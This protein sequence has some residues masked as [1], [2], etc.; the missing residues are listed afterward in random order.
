M[1][2][3]AFTELNALFQLPLS[4]TE[5][6]CCCCL[7]SRCVCVFSSC[8]AAVDGEPQR[9]AL[10]HCSAGYGPHLPHGDHGEPHRPLSGQGGWYVPH[11]LSHSRNISFIP[12]CTSL[13]HPTPTLFFMFYLCFSF[14]PSLSYI[15]LIWQYVRRLRP[16][17]ALTIL[18]AI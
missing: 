5:Y 15:V 1:Q 13:P 6:S 14:I 11:W 16:Y 17:I 7:M 4:D 18:S 8:H 9:A 3:S 10:G 2:F 12:F